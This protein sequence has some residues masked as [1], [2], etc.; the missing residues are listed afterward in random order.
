VHTTMFKCCL[1]P[2]NFVQDLIILY[3][4]VEVWS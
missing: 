4:F 1:Q 2:R 3:S